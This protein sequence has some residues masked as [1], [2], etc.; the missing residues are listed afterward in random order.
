[1]EPITAKRLFHLVESV[2]SEK[3]VKIIDS[4]D[5]KSYS[6]TS[7]GNSYKISKNYEVEVFTYKYE[8]VSIELETAYNELASNGKGI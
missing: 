1:M 7:N 3:I 5:C 8:S 2:V 4:D 6:V